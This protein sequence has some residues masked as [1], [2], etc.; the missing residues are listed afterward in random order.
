MAIDSLWSSVTALLQMVGENNSTNIMDVKQHTFTAYGDAKLTT[1]DY[2]FGASG[3]CLTIDGTGDYVSTPGST[4]FT[5]GSGDFIIEVIFKTTDNNCCLLDFFTSG[6]PGWQV[7]ITAA[8]KLNLYTSASIKTGAVT[9]NDGSWRYAAITR[10]SGSIHFYTCVLGGSL[11]EDGT[12]TANSTNL[13]YVT[14]YFSVGAQV[15]IRN[16][17]YDFSGNIGPVR[18]TKG[19]A[20]PGFTL[21]S[22]LFPCPTISG[23]VLDA[24]AAPASKVVSAIKRS[25]LANVVSKV[26]SGA[27]GIYSLWTI[28]YSEH[29]VCRFDT[30]TYPMVDGGS[31]ENAL[32]YD[33]VI[34]V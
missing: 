26:S 4:D 8:G 28:D 33:R 29:F 31:G 34:P 13:S 30:S 1:T 6:N 7:N 16:T 19:S 32:I 2:P 9:V 18:I 27:D 17:A 20:R 10:A 22:A 14:S 24:A 11:A 21:P 25:T 15:A 3:S 12:G 5:L 23:I